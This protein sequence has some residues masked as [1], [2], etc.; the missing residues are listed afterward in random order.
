MKKIYLLAMLARLLLAKAVTFDLNRSPPPSPCEPVSNNA[1][2]PIFK[3]GEQAEVKLP[4]ATQMGIESQKRK[5]NKVMDILSTG[6]IPSNL[7]DSTKRRRRML[8]KMSQEERDR[9]YERKRKYEKENLP[10]RK[11]SGK[12][13]I[14]A[15]RRRNRISQMTEGER[16]AYYKN[17][18]ESEKQQYERRKART[19]YG[20]KSNQLE[21]KIRKKMR[22]DQATPGE[23][24][25]IEKKRHS[26]AKQYQKKKARREMKKEEN[27]P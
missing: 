14:D 13:A 18:R 7:A 25:I 26:D 27:R 2:A 10:S 3:V 12:Y 22:K 16:E 23:I 6:T 15:E 20:R 21:K 4:N 24:A 19:G 9:F 17:K 8:S 11:E 1:T 5:R